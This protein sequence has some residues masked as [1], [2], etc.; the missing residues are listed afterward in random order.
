[1]VSFD[2]ISLFPSIPVDLAIEIVS[3]RWEEVAKHTIIPKDLFLRI[4]K[5][6]TKENRF[7]EYEGKIYTQLKGMPM[8]SALS[9]ILADIVLEELLDKCLDN[10][11]NKPR[12]LTK[13][14]DDLF[15]VI[16]KDDT[17]KTLETLNKF[18]KHIKFTVETEKEGKLPYLD[19]IAVIINNKIKIDW[20]QKPTA[21]GRII[22]FH[23]K[24]PRNMIIN[25]ANNFVRRVLSTSDPVFHQNNKKKILEILNK[26]GFPEA[27]SRGL[28][29]KF[30]NKKQRS[31]NRDQPR[32]YKSVTYVPGLTETF[33]KSNLYNKEEFA[34]AP[35]INNTVQQYYTQTK[36][37]I[38]DEEKSNVVYKIQCT[39]NEEQNCN[40]F[41]VGTTKNKLKARISQHK[42]DQR[43]RR[44]TLM[45]QKTA[46]AAHC[47][48]HKHTADFENTKVLCEERHYTKR[49]TLEM[50][51]IAQTPVEQRI[52]YKTDSDNV[53]QVY[54]NLITQKPVIK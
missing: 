23:S 3:R 21:S 32:K 48:T 28:I 17:Q 54:R 47:A 12:L 13:Y 42:Y 43:L 45:E 9:P 37:K 46:L 35:N 44:N 5:F 10:L 30:Y 51:H 31:N 16:R 40:M 22:N 19:S 8:G 20:Y 41:Y 49:L 34:L 11:E 50:L 18:H 6:T 1:M 39:G 52:N 26:N 14:V 29:N 38:A 27:T 36:T 24:H 53:A 4:L 15:C 33:I 7:F 25:T 2:V